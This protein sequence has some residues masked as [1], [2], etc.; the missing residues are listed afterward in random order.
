MKIDKS[1]GIPIPFTFSY[2]SQIFANLASIDQRTMQRNSVMRVINVL[3]YNSPS[4]RQIRRLVGR[5]K[6]LNAPA[7][8]VTAIAPEPLRYTKKED[9]PFAVESSGYR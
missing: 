5:P 1:S 4:K 7:E 3:R 8:E 9:A 2:K 6:S